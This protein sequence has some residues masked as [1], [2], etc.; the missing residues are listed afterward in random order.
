MSK[1][2]ITFFFFLLSCK[3]LGAQENNL[4]FINFG[5]KEGLTDNFAYNAAQDK[6]GYMWFA[7]PSGLYRYAGRIF[8]IFRSTLDKPGRAISNIL[9][10][11]FTAKNGTLWLGGFNT[12]QWYN[13][14]KNIFFGP[15]YNKPEVKKL[16]D[17]YIVSF[18][19]EE[20]SKKIWIATNRDYF[21]KFNAADSAFIWFGGLYPAGA[22]KAVNKII[23]ADNS[24][25]AIHAEGIYQFS[26]DDKFMGFYGIE[27]ANLSNAVYDQASGALELVSYTKG[28]LRFNLKEKKYEQHFL[29]NTTLKSN[30]LYNIIKDN[31]NNSW[32]GAF[33]LFKVNSDKTKPI[34]IANKKE[35]EY[36]LNTTT[37]GSLFFD[38]EKNVW[39][40][41]NTG[42]SMMPWQN[43]QIKTIPLVDNI[44]GNTIE[45]IG[46]YSI[47]NSQ[48]LLIAS[49]TSAGL[50]YY[51]T[52]TGK[53]TTLQNSLLTDK[54]FK[55]IN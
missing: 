54:N 53:V 49:T 20:N 31:E 42:L 6:Q 12:I 36:D 47:T 33:T 11:V 23:I 19:E 45:P 25:W 21:F 28:I 17:A 48:D 1:H 15:D 14:A 35:G 4:R 50:V 16:C 26:V 51:E 5:V 2:I 46:V 7:A 27:S 29:A 24:I 9:Q 32:I 40:C 52:V 30:N 37:N 43:Q 41:G 44:S 8:K 38:K 18:T 10:T 13:P 3:G 39:I 34:T 22:S 55:N